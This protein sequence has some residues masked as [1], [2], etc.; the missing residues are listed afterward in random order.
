VAGAALGWAVVLNARQEPGLRCTWPWRCRG[1]PSYSSSSSS[2]Q[3]S[4]CGLLA[5][6]P[7]MVALAAC[8]QH[9]CRGSH[10][11]MASLVQ[12][13]VCV[14]AAAVGIVGNA[15]HKASAC[16]VMAPTSSSVLRGGGGPAVLCNVGFDLDFKCCS[17]KQQ[18]LAL[19]ISCTCAPRTKAIF[20]FIPLDSLYFQSTCNT[21]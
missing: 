3:L 17:Y 15:W 7:C 19:L 11:C 14:A 4:R 9:A 20:L 10:E 8:F 21:D 2:T 16:R 18:L 13:L 6:R 5:G 12:R 1:P